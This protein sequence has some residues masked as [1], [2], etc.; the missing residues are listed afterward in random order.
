MATNPT[1]NPY[2]AALVLRS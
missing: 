2:R 1:Y